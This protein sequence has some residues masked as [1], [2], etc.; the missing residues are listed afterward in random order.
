MQLKNDFVG[1]SRNSPEKVGGCFSIEGGGLG[2]QRIHSCKLTEQSCRLS[3]SSTGM[4]RLPVHW[5][6][7]SAKAA[8]M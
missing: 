8:L 3:L 2:D 5:C 4:R 1:G 7:S 6:S